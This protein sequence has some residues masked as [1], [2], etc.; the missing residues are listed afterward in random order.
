[1]PG[2]ASW[3]GPDPQ[4]DVPPS[5]VPR[6][7]RSPFANTGIA[8]SR[9]FF[10]VGGVNGSNGAPS[11]QTLTLAGSGVGSIRL[12]WGSIDV[13]N[14]II[15]NGTESVT[16]DDVMEVINADLEDPITPVGAGTYNTVALIEF[17]LDEAITSLTFLSERDLDV[18]GGPDMPAMEFALAPVPLPAAGLML[19]AGLGALAALRRTRS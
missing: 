17:S 1:M 3:S 18:P 5:T 10:A 15:F 13:F 8:D 6:S 16:G 4:V 12:L 14:E 9:D 2:G 19:L 7:Y 11:P